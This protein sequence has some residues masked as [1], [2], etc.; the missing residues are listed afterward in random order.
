[1]KIIYLTDTIVSNI[2]QVLCSILGIKEFCF[3]YLFL[4]CSFLVG[5]NKPR[6]CGLVVIKKYTDF[7]L[8]ITGLKIGSQGRRRSVDY[9]D[10]G[11]S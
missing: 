9:V 5:R 3:L 2:C 6:M 7:F 10:H 1:M 4:D 11:I 8:N